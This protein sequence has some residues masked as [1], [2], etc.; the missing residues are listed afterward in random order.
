MTASVAQVTRTAQWAPWWFLGALEGHWGLAGGPRCPV[1]AVFS[2]V[3]VA[4]VVDR[5]CGPE[6]FRD[7]AA[8]GARARSRL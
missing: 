2:A 4:A 8:K 3:A 7:R 6:P 5:S 1:S